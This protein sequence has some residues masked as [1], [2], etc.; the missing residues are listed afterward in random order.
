MC[1]FL[2]PEDCATV[3]ERSK[4][5]LEQQCAE[6]ILPL[7]KDHHLLLVTLLLFNTVANEA[8]PVFLDELVPSWAA[9]LLLG[10]ES[11]KGY[12]KEVRDS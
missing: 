9:L 2:G 6:R 8:L 1:L 11:Y 5:K 10:I 12:G 7:V 3:E 4:L